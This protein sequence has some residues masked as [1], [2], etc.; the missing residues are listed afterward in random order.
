M[1]AEARR[2]GLSSSFYIIKDGSKRSTVFELDLKVS[3]KHTDYITINSIVQ[4]HKLYKK[5]VEEQ[6]IDSTQGFKQ[7]SNEMTNIKHHMPKDRKFK[8]PVK[9]IP[10][11][12]RIA[13]K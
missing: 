7:I 1:A 5:I 12:L 8:I 11:E 3:M 13:F 4:I 2:W 6:S 9:H 10:I